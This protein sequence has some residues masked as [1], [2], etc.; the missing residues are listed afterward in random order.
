[1]NDQLIIII[2]VGVL[3]LVWARYFTTRAAYAVKRLIKEGEYRART[4]AFN[5]L[6]HIGISTESE[7]ES[8]LSHAGKGDWLDIHDMVLPK[9]T[10]IDT[11]KYG[12]VWIVN[13]LGSDW[14]L[15]EPQRIVTGN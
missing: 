10:L 9:G 15:T 7:L 11:R 12:A 3:A 6:N 5:K 14:P 2:I 4:K 13:C 1:M 8:A